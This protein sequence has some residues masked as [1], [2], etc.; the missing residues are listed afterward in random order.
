MPAAAVSTSTERS[1]RTYVEVGDADVAYK[2]VGDGVVDLVYFY[3]LG[4][5][6]YFFDDPAAAGWIEECSPCAG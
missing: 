6:D 1:S 4:S 3:G 5:H 2:V